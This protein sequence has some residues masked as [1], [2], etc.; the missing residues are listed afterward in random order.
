MINLSPIPKIIQERMREKMDAVG[1]D[2][3]YYPDSDTPK[4]TQEKMLSRSP[5]MRM[6]SGQKFPVVLMGGELKPLGGGQRGGFDEVYASARVS[7]H[8][9]DIAGMKMPKIS[10]NENVETRPIPGLKSINATYQGGMKAHRTATV[11]WICWSFGDLERLMPHFLAHGKTV[12]VQWGW[13]YDKDSLVRIDSFTKAGN[14]I[15][16]DA[17]NSNHLRDII[18]NYGDYDMMTGVIK[19]F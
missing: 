6:V 11:S 5:F 18:D 3:P 4:L 17:F 19:N 12:M 13:I 8:I 9:E 1:R 2:T 14:T 7:T 15:E 10:I 16:E